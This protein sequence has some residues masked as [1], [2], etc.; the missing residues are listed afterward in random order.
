MAVDEAE[1]RERPKLELVASEQL[2]EE[3]E[4]FRRLR[5]D[6]PGTQGA[7]AAGIVS[8]GVSKI[9]GKN[10]FFRTHKDFHPVVSIVDADIGM[11]RH[12]FAVTDAMTEALASIGI[13]TALHTLYLTMTARNALRIVPVRCEGGEGERNEFAA[14][15]ELG[16]R[17]GMT[18]WV[19]LYTDME[20]RCYRVFP[21]P[22]G[23]FPDP[24]WPELK[25]AKIFRLAF[26]DR[27][28]L[29][30]SVEHALFKKCAARDRD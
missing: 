25:P 27:G 23:R 16:L 24:V 18:E 21:A 13:P 11:E 8:I 12:F 17:Q 9:P 5:R 3:E 1:E 26:R 4:E 30:D 15:K 2:D 28:H 29:I 14:T 22:V 7:A 19:R 6:L 20:N 10:E